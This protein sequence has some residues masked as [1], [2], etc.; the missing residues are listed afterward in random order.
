E[1]GA[2]REKPQAEI[3]TPEGGCPDNSEPDDGCYVF[4]T[5]GTTGEGKAILGRHKSLYHF[6]NWEINEFQLDV[7]CRVSQLLLVV[8]DPWF[9]DVFVP[10]C[11][12]GTLCIPPNEIRDNML[13]LLEWLNSSRIT[14]M[15]IVPTIFRL[16]TKEFE[17]HGQ[18]HEFFANL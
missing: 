7:T 17:R 10:L 12:G 5:S 3:I 4:F 18:R 9:R 8:F 6:I 16:L 14:L 13:Q 15:H 11:S 1:E 2:L